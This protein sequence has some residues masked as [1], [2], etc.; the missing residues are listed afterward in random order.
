MT[1][2]TKGMGAIIKKLGTA[3]RNKASKKLFENPVY[4]PFKK[5]KSLLDVTPR[6]IIKSVV[7]DAKSVAKN[8]TVVTGTIAAGINEVV[9]KEKEKK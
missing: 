8:K 4:K 3:S 1:L 5:K 2:L 7:K 6:K 9:K